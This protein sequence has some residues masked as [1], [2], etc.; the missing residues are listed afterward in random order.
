MLLR[1]IILIIAGVLA[2]PAQ[3]VLGV[4]WLQVMPLGIDLSGNYL[5]MVLVPVV[6]CLHFAIALVLWKAFEPAPGIASVVFVA[7]HAVSQGLLLRL[8]GNPLGDVLTT[9]VIVVL[10][11]ALVTTV[12][13][14]F[15]WCPRCSVPPS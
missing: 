8:L 13:S 3:E 12:F 15:I 2:A 10:S 9:C 6:L 14:Q 4:L 11:G 5:L 7:S 1:I